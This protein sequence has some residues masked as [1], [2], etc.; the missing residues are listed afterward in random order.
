MGNT[1][2]VGPREIEKVNTVFKEDFVDNEKRVLSNLVFLTQD[3]KLAKTDELLKRTTGDSFDS[4]SSAEIKSAACSEEMTMDLHVIEIRRPFAVIVG[5][6]DYADKERF[7]FLESCQRECK[8]MKTIFLRWGS[9][10]VLR[11]NLTKLKISG[12]SCESLCS[13]LILTFRNLLQ[14]KSIAAK[15]VP[16]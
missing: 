12:M 7:S 2:S 15:F 16:R 4:P 10:V 1:T 6:Y 14:C 9:E 8:T 13:V 3:E 5:N 11:E